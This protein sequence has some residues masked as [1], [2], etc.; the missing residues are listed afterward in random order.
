MGKI[1]QLS[2]ILWYLFI[3]ASYWNMTNGYPYPWL[4]Q[5]GGTKDQAEWA[6]FFLLGISNMLAGLIIDKWKAK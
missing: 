2:G 3:A 4:G 5:E 1:I 6:C